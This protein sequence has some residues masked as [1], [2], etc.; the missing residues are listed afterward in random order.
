MSGKDTSIRLVVEVVAILFP[1]VY[2]SKCRA[3]GNLIH[4]NK[5]IKSAFDLYHKF[6]QDACFCTYIIT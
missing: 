3:F 2:H 6:E 1:D 4:D 5:S